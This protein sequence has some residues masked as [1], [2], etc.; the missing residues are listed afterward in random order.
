MCVCV[1][2]W[3]CTSRSASE[4]SHRSITTTVA[5]A[6]SGAAMENASGA[7]WYMGPVQR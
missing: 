3:S 1:I 2:P 4:A 5:P 6:Q 7:A